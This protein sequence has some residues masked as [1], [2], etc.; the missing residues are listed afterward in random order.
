[1][2]A[3]EAEQRFRGRIYSVGANRCVDVPDRVSRALGQET[4]I[5]VKGSVGGEPFRST[6]VPRG[7]GRHRLF[8][9]S[10]IWRK[11]GVDRGRTVDIRLR[12]DRSRREARL[13]GDIADALAAR[14]KA[15]AAFENMT[16][17]GR[18][19]FVSYILEAKTGPT[20]ERRIRQGL[21]RIVDNRRK[22]ALRSGGNP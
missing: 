14:P 6:L 9:H 4:R 22:K 1:M 19:A 20:R 2:K 10:R 5:P 16:P 13:P 7:G 8:I 12:G 21:Q 15:R 11:L 17:A 3:R 18:R